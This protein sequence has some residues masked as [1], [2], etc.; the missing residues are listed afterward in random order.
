MDK[1]IQCI[2]DKLIK[3]LTCHQYIDET[4]ESVYYYGTIVAIQS[5]L[6]FMA[7]LIIGLV[8]GLFFE[9][10]CFFIVF[11]LIRKFSGGFHSENFTLCF[12]ISV[13]LNI[14]FLFSFKLFIIYPDFILTILIQ[15]ISSVFV[16]F[17]SPVT[18]INKVVSTKEYK[19]YK[20]V[21]G[22]ACLV[23]FL[24][25]VFLVIKKSHFVYS[26]CIATLFD[27]FF[28]LLGKIKYLK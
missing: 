26:I 12:M 2:S 16:T 10:L 6:N 25:S 23:A 9:N 20:I 19:I 1:V 24:C 11:R 15:F 27:C 18:N 13:A 14:L 22:T 4:K 3:Y 7:T 21:V 17:L 5:I 28:V 8:F